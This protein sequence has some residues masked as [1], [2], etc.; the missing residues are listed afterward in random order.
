[1]MLIN[2]QSWD[3][4]VNFLYIYIYNFIEVEMG[5]AYTVDVW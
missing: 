4:Q 2:E 1:M 3:S 5:L